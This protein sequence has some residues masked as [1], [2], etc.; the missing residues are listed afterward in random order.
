[1]LEDYRKKT[2]QIETESAAILSQAAREASAYVNETRAA[3]DEMMTRR[4]NL[5]E[6]K[7]KQEEERARKEIR[8]EAAALA[9]A[10]ARELLE[11][12]VSGQLADDM[13][14][15]SIDKIKKRLN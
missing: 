12:K 9:I 4:M 8:A 6:L 13:I 14:A 5:A 7:I 10:A 11:Q 1:L 15:S 2:A 3:F